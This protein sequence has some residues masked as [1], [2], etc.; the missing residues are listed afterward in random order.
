MERFGA[1]ALVGLLLSGCVTDL[2]QPRPQPWSASF[3]DVAVASGEQLVR[4]VTPFADPVVRTTS[5]AQIE[6]NENVLYVVPGDDQP[7]AMFISEGTKEASSIDVTLT[8]REGGARI[9]DLA[10]MTNRAV[11]ESKADAQIKSASKPKVGAVSIEV[12]EPS[13]WGRPCKTCRDQDDEDDGYDR[14]KW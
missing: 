14:G 11:A 10:Q 1:V 9:V 8:P 4:V 2:A 7:I 13:P 12:E 6:P 3:P 5:L